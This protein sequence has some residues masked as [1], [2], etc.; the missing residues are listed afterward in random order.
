MMHTLSFR[1]GHGAYALALALSCLSL[2]ACEKKAEE[3]EKSDTSAERKLLSPDELRSSFAKLKSDTQKQA[4][5]FRAVRA[6]VNDFPPDLIGLSSFK[7]RISPIESSFGALLGRVTW[8]EGELELA[9]REKSDER[10]RSMEAQ[11]A[12]IAGDLVH[13]GGTLS[14]LE[15]EL[16]RFDEDVARQTSW[17]YRLPGGHEVR[18]APGGL[19]RNLID[20][21]VSDERALDPHA[22]FRFDRLYFVDLKSE[23]VPPRSESQLENVVAILKA[24]PKL[25]L[26]LTAFDRDVQ[27]REEMRQLVTDRLG[28]LKSELEKRGVAPGRL[29]ILSHGPDCPPEAPERCPRSLAARPRTDAP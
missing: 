21:V 3:G 14:E 16:P 7:G 4:N 17:V 2:G 1:S 9:L 15:R 11:I 24:Y 29:R 8:L 12:S 27:R 5:S 13:T 26:E 10:L 25:K 28:A 22:W 19:E 23:F 18:A 20:F 6:R